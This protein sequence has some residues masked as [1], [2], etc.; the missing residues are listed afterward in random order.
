MSRIIKKSPIWKHFDDCKKDNAFAVCKICPPNSVK[1]R[2]KKNA[3]GGN[4]GFGTSNM[5]SH[6]KNYHPKELEAISG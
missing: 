2:V 1:G 5:K 6:L 4:S 3:N